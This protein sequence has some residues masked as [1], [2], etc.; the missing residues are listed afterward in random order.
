MAKM[1]RYREEKKA[2][3]VVVGLGWRVEQLLDQEPES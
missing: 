3:G 1:G 2:L